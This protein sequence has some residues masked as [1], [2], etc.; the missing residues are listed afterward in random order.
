VHS[1]ARSSLVLY[2]AASAVLGSGCAVLTSSQVDAARGFAK[3]TK[4]YVAVPAKVVDAYAA[5]HAERE[6]LKLAGTRTDA[7]QKMDDIVTRRLKWRDDSE[8][9]TGALAVLNAYAELLDTLAQPGLADA[10]DALTGMGTALDG[11]IAT[12]NAKRGTSLPSLGSAI[13]AGARALG[14]VVYAQRQAAIIK[15]SVDAADDVI[16]PLLNDIRALL[17]PYASKNADNN[18][19]ADVEALKGELGLAASK[20]AFGSDE[21]RGYY[22]AL[23]ALREGQRLA[24]AAIEAT[25]ACGA[26]HRKLKEA[27][28]VK[29]SLG[30]LIDEVRAYGDQVS[31]AMKVKAEVEDAEKK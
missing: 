13:A 7:P 11:T 2:L 28:A 10:D 22:G 19:A 15:A 21:A 18:F 17:W 14:G 16:Q 25:T 26:A 9:V 23:L 4:D 20:P 24:D 8:Q 6:V 31:A 12:Y 1:G 3:V 5:A 30:H 29:A 27:L